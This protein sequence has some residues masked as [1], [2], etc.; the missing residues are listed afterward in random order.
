MTPALDPDAFDVLTFDCYGTLIDWETGMLAAFARALPGVPADDALLA[1]Y[2]THEARLEHGPFLSY[3]QI[4]AGALRG[5]AE[6]L[7][8]AVSDEAA[9][10][11]ADSVRDW[12]AFPDSGPALARLHTRFRLAVVTNCDV[13]LFAASHARLGVRFDEVITAQQVGSYKPSHANFKA[14]FRALDLP[15]DRVLHVAQS[16]FH[17]HVPAKELGLTTV[18]IDRR[19][20]RAGAGATPPAEATPDLRFLSMADFAAHAVPG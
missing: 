5:V 4:L 19:H 7:G 3:R 16:L 1:R 11:F 2:A 9:A 14:A 20:G 13:D 12:P 15:P 17:D 8:R 18:W 6:D 10:A